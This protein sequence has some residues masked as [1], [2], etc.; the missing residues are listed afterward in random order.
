M[1]EGTASSVGSFRS[2]FSDL[3]FSIG[4]LGEL[5]P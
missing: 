1:S 5:F 2:G 4:L 3:V